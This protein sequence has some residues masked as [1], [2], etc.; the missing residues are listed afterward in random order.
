MTW[1][2]LTK[3]LIEILLKL[4]LL[5]KEAFPINR[6]SAQGISHACSSPS[7]RRLFMFHFCM[8][9]KQQLYK[10]TFAHI[11]TCVS[12]VLELRH[13]TTRRNLN[14][15]LIKFST[16]TRGLLQGYVDK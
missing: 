16:W 7:I 14:Y 13:K 3:D 12:Q 10:T 5:T 9:P 15:G 2:R 8:I 4:R 1:I 6:C 11:F